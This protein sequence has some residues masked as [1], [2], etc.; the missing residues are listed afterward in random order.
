MNNIQL[1]IA[2]RNKKFVAYEIKVDDIRPY[3]EQFKGQIP[4]F[5]TKDLQTAI[6]MAQDICNEKNI[7]FYF[8]GFQN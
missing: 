2:F 6:I 3:D 1:A 5:S 7:T 4:S 8:I